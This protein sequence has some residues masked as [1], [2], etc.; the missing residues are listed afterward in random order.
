MTFR[1]SA[2]A[3]PG[4]NLFDESRIR[5]LCEKASIRR[6]KRFREVHHNLL[7]ITH[8]VLSRK[9]RIRGFQKH[10]AN[11]SSSLRKLIICLPVNISLFGKKYKV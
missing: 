7:H 11:T 1:A 10:A 4:E 9:R 5:G 2:I 3:A 8:S 6:I